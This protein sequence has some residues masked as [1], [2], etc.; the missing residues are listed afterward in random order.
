MGGTSN[1]YLKRKK[2]KV[3]KKRKGDDND[4]GDYT[5]DLVAELLVENLSTIRAKI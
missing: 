5:R 1:I 3:R 2:E 4:E